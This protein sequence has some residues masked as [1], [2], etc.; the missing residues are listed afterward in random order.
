MNQIQLRLTVIFPAILFMLVAVLAFHSNYSNAQGVA[1]TPP[2][3]SLPDYLR[4]DSPLLR[5]S[6]EELETKPIVPPKPKAVPL[7]NA[8]RD[9]VIYNANTRQ[10]TVIQNF[11][12]PES[13]DAISSDEPFVGVL[14]YRENP[15][16][17]SVL[18]TDGRSQITNTGSYPWRT[19]ARLRIK[20]PGS[21][22]IWGCSGA[23]VDNF[24]ILV[25]GHCV[26][27]SDKGGW[28]SWIE[29]YPGQNGSQTPYHLAN[30]ISARS[31]TGWTVN[32]DPEHDFALITLDRSVGNFTGWMGRNTYATT[33]S[34]YTGGLNVSGYPCDKPSGTHWYDF[35]N[36]DSATDNR[37][38]Y[39]MDTFGCQSG[40]PVWLLLSASNTRYIL[41]VHAYG[42]GAGTPGISNGGTRLNN[43]KRSD[44]NTWRLSD[45]SPT[46]KPDMIDDGN[47]YSG[48]SPTSAF[49]NQSISIYNDV[50]NIGTANASGF[51]VSFY[52]SSNTIITSA[53]YFLGQVW[54]SGVTPFNSTD[55]NLNGSLPANI[56]PGSYY[57]GWIIDSSGTNAE[58]DESNNRAYKSSPKL[59]VETE[60]VVDE[61]TCFPISIG[62]GKAS[63]ICL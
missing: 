54:V 2:Q 12:Q 59:T 3:T 11:S 47:A 62:N 19:I 14:P 9:T 24:H 32:Q 37:H 17:E 7:T 16:Q 48:F 43:G 31:Y 33:A 55:A 56:P 18:G 35:D 29:V 45:S 58:F 49:P 63:I 50:R 51:Y 34:E 36:G 44:I 42:D 41:T 22:S 26:H 10:E 40:A 52:A 5:L 21:A 6:A 60:T 23:M 1:E 13:Y 38:F 61:E 15:N 20:Y 53:D 46:D 57:I 25:A 4:S 27:A 28:Y 30:A 8:P 39:Y